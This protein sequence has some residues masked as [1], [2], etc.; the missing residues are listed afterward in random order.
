[1]S[2]SPWAD[3]NWLDKGFIASV[4]RCQKWSLWQFICIFFNTFTEI[5]SIYKNCIFLRYTTWCFDI[6]CENITTIKLIN[7]PITSINLPLCM[8][9]CVCVV[10]RLRSILFTNFKSTVLCCAVP[11]LVAQ[12]RLTLATPQTVA[13]QAPLFMGFCRQVLEWVAVSSSSPTP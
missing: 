2:R 1:M 11:C 10:R 12:P 3:N 8:C 6:H 13:C 4:D 9:V 5:A 7:T